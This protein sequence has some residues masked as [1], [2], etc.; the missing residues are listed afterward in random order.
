METYALPKPIDWV[1]LLDNIRDEKCLLILGPEVYAD[2]LGEPIQQK[3]LKNLD[4]L[5]NPFV[6]RY[7]SEEDFYFFEHK[8]HR[9]QFC[10]QLKNFYRQEEPGDLI[11]L[12]SEIPFHIYLTVTP[13][14][15]LPEIFKRKTF[16]FQHGFYKKNTDPQPI[17]KPSAEMPLIYNL[18]GCI[19]SAESLVLSHND[20]YDFFKSIFARRSM[21]GE[22]K[23]ELRDVRNLLFLGV[24]F[25]KWYLQILLREFEIHTQQYDF[26]RFAANQ[27]PSL[28]LCT[29]CLDQFQIQFI[30]KNVGEFVRELHKRVKADN[31]ISLRTSSGPL[32]NSNHAVRQKLTDGD[33]EGALENLLKIQSN[34][35]WTNEVVLL[36]GRYNRLKSRQT[37]GM[38]GSGDS[39]LEE[40]NISHSII[41]LLKKSVA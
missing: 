34:P 1:Y 41:E 35:E 7:Y 12:L 25:D 22:L 40:N 17:V 31:S 8:S 28:E 9:T 36:H 39:L 14:L 32:A 33:I 38:I 24:P 19:E 15:L 16:S 26:A 37:A 20:L 18:L 30:D 5:H 3:L 4:I 29:L 23:D 13:D 11:G 2:L 21:P 27:N 6:R 10:H